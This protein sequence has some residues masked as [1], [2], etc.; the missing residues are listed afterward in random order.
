MNRRYAS[1]SLQIACLVAIAILAAGCY[2]A[3]ITAPTPTAVPTPQ[4]S[5]Q[6]DTPGNEE[7]QPIELDNCGGKANALIT[8]VTFNR[9]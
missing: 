2:G 6:G 7:V 3:P 5:I 1:T 4:V 9:R 8:Q